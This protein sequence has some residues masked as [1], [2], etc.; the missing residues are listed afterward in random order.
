MSVEPWRVKKKKKKN[1]CRTERKR[2]LVGGA[3]SHAGRPWL[4][5]SLRDA[6]GVSVASL[7]SFV[8][9]LRMADDD[10]ANAAAESS[11]SNYHSRDWAFWRIL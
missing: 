4:P 5:K 11:L 8:F 1:I 7:E 10:Y 2:L 6:P 3:V 9:P